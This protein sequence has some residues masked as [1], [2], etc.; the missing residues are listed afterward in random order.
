MKVMWPHPFP[1]WAKIAIKRLSPTGRRCAFL[2]LR[3]YKTQQV[4]YFLGISRRSVEAYM[5]H[6]KRNCCKA[7]GEKRLAEIIKES[8]KPREWS[9]REVLEL[10]DPYSCR[11]LTV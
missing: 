1:V 4:A 8:E 7:I 3:E 10:R 2:L 11:T 9:L 6:L 5:G